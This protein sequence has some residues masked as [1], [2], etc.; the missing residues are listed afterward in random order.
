MTSFVASEVSRNRHHEHEATKDEIMRKQAEEEK[1]KKW[2]EGYPV[3]LALILALTQTETQLKPQL[4]L[5][6]YICRT[7]TNRCDSAGRT[8]AWHILPTTTVGLEDDMNS[9]LSR[10]LT[11][12]P[13]S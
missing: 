4:K 3:T 11:F 12:R 9:G 1:I 8:C 10:K 6:I 5:K 7:N 2:Q 13:Y